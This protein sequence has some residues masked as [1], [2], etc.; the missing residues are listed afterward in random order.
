MAI[1]EQTT[2]FIYISEKMIVLSGFYDFL[3]KQK[4]M[5]RKGELYCIDCGVMKMSLNSKQIE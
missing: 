3:N 1:T 5:R 4:M 2:G